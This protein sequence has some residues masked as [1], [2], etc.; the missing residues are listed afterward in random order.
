LRERERE[1][2]RERDDKTNTLM[3][4]VFLG[5]DGGDALAGLGAEAEGLGMLRPMGAML[6]VFVF[7]FGGVG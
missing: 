2:E 4:V 7:V 6:R 1:R 5:L 3:A